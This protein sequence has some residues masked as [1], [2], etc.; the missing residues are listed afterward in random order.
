MLS[1]FLSKHRISLSQHHLNG[2]PLISAPNAPLLFFTW[3]IH[4]YCL[5]ELEVGRKKRQ[6]GTFRM[7]DDRGTLVYLF[8]LRSRRAEIEAH[9]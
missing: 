9:S 7:K 6:V 3:T 5:E 4:T 8:P 1:L 2:A